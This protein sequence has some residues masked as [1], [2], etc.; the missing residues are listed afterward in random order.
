MQLTVEAVSKFGF[1]S[2]TKWYNP[3]KK[4]GISLVGLSKGDLVE[5]QTNTAGW[6]TSLEIVSSGNPLPTRADAA[7]TTS[8]KS[9]GTMGQTRTREEII[10]SEAAA[11]AARLVAGMND[12]DSLQ[13]TNEFRNLV[14]EIESFITTGKLA[15]TAVATTA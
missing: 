3:D 11:S 12:L 2:G 1:K 4:S 15:T 10:R 6:V 14:T 5:I 13:K 9:S 7:G 8:A